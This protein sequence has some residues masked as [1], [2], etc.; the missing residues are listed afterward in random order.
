MAGWHFITGSHF[1][2]HVCE[3]DVTRLHH[4]GP[5]WLAERLAF[6]LITNRTDLEPFITAEMLIFAPK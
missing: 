1:T 5:P 2:S 4:D 3:R 6:E